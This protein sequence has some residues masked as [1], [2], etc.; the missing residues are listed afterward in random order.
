MKMKTLQIILLFTVGFLFFQC[1]KST[2]EITSVEA[3]SSY[4]NENEEVVAFGK[5]S[6]ETVLK[7]SDYKN[8][9]TVGGII[10]GLMKE[11][12]RG[13]EINDQVYYA[14]S[15]PIKSDGSLNDLE[16][17][18]P[19]KDKK[20]LK[21]TLGGALAF[22]VTEGKD[23][24]IASDENMAIA[25][26]DKMAILKFSEKID[27]PE[28]ELSAILAKSTGSE[29][30]GEIADVIESNGDVVFA[31]NTENAVKNSDEVKTLSQPQQEKLNQ[32][33][34]DGFAKTTFNFENGK[35][36]IDFNNSFNDELMLAMP[37]SED[38]TAPILA[39]L[40]SGKPRIGFSL[41]MD[42]SK[43]NS[44]LTDVGAEGLDAIFNEILP[45]LEKAFGVSLGLSNS[46]LNLKPT[47]LMS[48]ELGVVLF[49]DPDSTGNFSPDYNTH[50]GLNDNGGL[51]SSLLNRAIEAMSSG[52]TK[53]AGGVS[54]SSSPK[55][56]NRSPLLIPESASNFGKSG[57]SFFFDLEGFPETTFD[58][59][60]GA[61]ELQSILKV[62]KFISFEYNNKGGSLQVIAKNGKEN[63]LKQA[64][65]TIVEDQLN[66][67]MNINY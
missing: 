46:G 26:L 12:E 7:K 27:D 13:I 28:K 35:A 58:S 16:I 25:I 10:E 47:K 17:F 18:L 39:K 1:S 32:Y 3:F 2:Q 9:E 49:G 36:V 29:S 57:V 11:A 22:E 59:M 43:M 66:S 44:L 65:Q 23:F 24:L 40:G 42:F 62:A 41:N 51:L 45:D 63:I 48:G 15:G 19:V 14:V 31:V 30:S 56:N 60:E 52:G 67:Q 8:L 54:Y 50:V 37:L 33:A 55:Y 21:N 64:M 53:D 61:Y 20:E 6:L 34:K 4:M 38:E 5:A